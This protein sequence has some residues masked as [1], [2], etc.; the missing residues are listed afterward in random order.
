VTVGLSLA[1]DTYLYHFENPSRF[2]TADNVPHFFEQRLN[3]DAGW[4]WGRA[5]YRF[6]GRTWETDAGASASGAGVGDDYD[7]FLNPDGNVIVY[8]TTAG[9]STL[10][11]RVSQTV[12]LATVGGWHARVGYAYRRDRADYHA[13]FSTTTMTNPV[14][15]TQFWNADRE[16]TIS[17][18]HEVC[19]GFSRDLR[20]AAPWHARVVADLSPATLARLA[21]LLP[22]KYPGQ[23]IVFIAKAMALD[24]SVELN[25]RRGGVSYGVA[26]GFI[27]TLNYSSANSFTRHGVRLG[28]QVGF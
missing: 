14:T 10:S 1:H 25:Y 9:A 28:G 23:P 24:A 8:G 26:A 15:R 2:N 17:Q 21:T 20:L 11:L 5:R 22:D 18:V 7:T 27:S 19:V 12:E 6:G 4:L 3:L 13:S 16:T